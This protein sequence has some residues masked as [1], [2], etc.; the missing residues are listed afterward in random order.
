MNQRTLPFVP[1]VLALAALFF[2]AQ[3][4]AQIDLR[5]IESVVETLGA[6]HGLSE[7]ERIRRG[8]RQVAE[9]W[10]EIDGDAQEFA[11][12]CALNFI[13]DSDELEGVFLRLQQALEQ[14]DGVAVRV[15]MNVGR[16]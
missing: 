6:T 9:R 13:S 5:V 3:T 7:E 11:E 15:E 2:P 4:K 8:V 16:D 1:V 10:W 12:F 14:I